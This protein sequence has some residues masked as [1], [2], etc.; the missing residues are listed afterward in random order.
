MGIKCCNHVASGLRCVLHGDINFLLLEDEAVIG[1]LAFRVHSAQ[2][3]VTG[4]WEFKLILS[5]QRELSGKERK[6]VRD[7]CEI[8]SALW[9]KKHP[10]KCTCHVRMWNSTCLPD[11]P[12]GLVTGRRY[13]T[14]ADVPNDTLLEDQYIE[15]HGHPSPKCGDCG[16]WLY[17]A[18]G[19]ECRICALLSR[20]KT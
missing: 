14:W 5:S 12:R 9:L 2:R 11:C 7:S 17:E 19:G 10:P 20:E 13:E 8:C 1:K 6:Q 18:N 15:R 4:L 3:Q 16:S